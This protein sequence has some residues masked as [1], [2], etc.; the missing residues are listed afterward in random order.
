[1]VSVPQHR[2]Q[3]FY[4]PG[5]FSIRGKEDL[6]SFV[7]P[8]HPSLFP[9][10]HCLMRTLAT[11]PHSAAVS[12]VGILRQICR[13]ESIR[14]CHSMSACRQLRGQISCLPINRKKSMYTYT[15]DCGHVCLPPVFVLSLGSLD[16]I[17]LGRLLN[18]IKVNESWSELLVR[19]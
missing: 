4:L 14:V 7:L 2:G 19:S 16:F 18:F 10:M 3:V 5:T 13:S 9:P 11:H 8:M 6:S 12:Q 1:M 15:S 17:F